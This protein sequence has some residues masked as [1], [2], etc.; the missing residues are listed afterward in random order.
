MADEKII[1]PSNRGPLIVL[2]SANGQ[3][4]VSG[5]YG[6]DAGDYG[7]N[8]GGTAAAN[9]TALQ[10][11]LNACQSSGGKVVVNDPGTYEFST[12]LT[13]YGNTTIEVGPGATLSPTAAV[14]TACIVS[15]STSNVKLTG[16]GV[17]VCTASTAPT[18][19]SVSGL[20]VE[21]RIEDSSGNA[22]SHVE[23]S[24]SPSPTTSANARRIG[25]P[26]NTCVILGDSITANNT[27]S[28]ATYTA[29][30]QRGY[31][32]WA[33]ILLGNKRLSIL[34]NAGV[35][36]ED[37]SDILAR[38][39]DDVLAYSPSWCIVQGPTNDQPVYFTETTTI[40]NL[41][42]I[43]TGL[44]NAGIRVVAMSIIPLGSDHTS[45][46]QQLLSRHRRINQ[47]IADYCAETPGMVFVDA[48][49]AVVDPAQTDADV[50]S[51]YYW[52]SGPA[53]H[54]S[55]KGA[56]AIGAAIKTALE[57][58]IPDRN[59]LLSSDADDWT[60]DQQTITSLSGD[61]T[62]LTATLTAHKR[63]AGDY[64][65]IAGVTE[66]GF[67]GLR[68]ILSVPTSSTFTMAGTGSGAASGTILCSGSQNLIDNGLMQGTGGSGGTGIT[69]TEVAAG[70]T[71]DRVAGTPTA[72]A[73][74][75]TRS[76]GVGLD[77]QI[78]ITS[79]A[80]GD[81]VQMYS[82]DVTARVFAGESVYGE[83]AI[84]AASTTNMNLLHLRIQA[85]DGGT[86]KNV[87]DGGHAD[88][89]DASPTA[90]YSGVL[91]TPVFTYSGAST[92]L[93]MHIRARFSGVGGATIKVGRARLVKV[94]D[95]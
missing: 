57:G 24:C 41:T 15:T 50:L 61:G 44:L 53:I 36:G 13:M 69:A 37:S 1:V 46:S 78:V 55:A 85:I 68:K 47:W 42:A 29:T 14:S 23:T 91:R 59:C 18:F 38:V 64:V 92:R 87:Y 65:T 22:V 52:D 77:Q 35:S 3:L 8:P 94:I 31:M 30:G 63:L 95:R 21:V 20:T 11:A 10:S 79:G 86:Q 60:S 72:V 88:F 40:A 67:N 27:Y 71:I 82:A 48:W 89:T 75:E 6:N 49:A 39:S 12:A 34:N 56:Y 62:T 70:W 66:A 90:D 32:T 2:V 26:A 81:M 5:A 25:R 74:T 28:A 80:D 43:Y 76:D 19:T 4:R 17:I 51:G 84:S 7:A 45:W 58:F 16:D 9:A 83:C 54:P 93:I 73:T 33:N